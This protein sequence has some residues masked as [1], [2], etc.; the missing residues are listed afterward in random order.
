MN[1]AAIERPTI[2]LP[3]RWLVGIALGLA[4]IAFLGGR[5]IFQRLGGYRPLALTHVPQ[6]M[7]YRARVE[8]HDAGRAPLLAPL[9]A[10]LDPEGRRWAGLEQKIGDSLRLVTREVAFGAGTDRSD[11]VL[12]LGLQLKD[13][14]RVQPGRAL[15]EVLLG[16][17]MRVELRESGCL[18]PEGSLVAEALDGTLVLASRP[19]LV[20]DLLGRPEIGDRMGFSGPSVRGVAPEVKELEHEVAALSQVLAAKYR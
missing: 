16:D 8:V 10:A 4:V 11:F 9:L 15:C 12:A 13:A 3:F 2:R 6:T 5:H 18:L 1:E 7:R 19:E 20:K 17:G 14:A